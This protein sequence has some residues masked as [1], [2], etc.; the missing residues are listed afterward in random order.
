MLR[1]ARVVARNIVR[2]S[3][4]TIYG[5]LFASGLVVAGAAVGENVTQ[6]KRSLVDGASIAGGYGVAD[7]SPI[8]MGVQSSWQQQWL[9]DWQWPLSG[10]WEASLYHMPGTAGV[11]PDSNSKISAIAFAPVFRFSKAR[12]STVNLASSTSSTNSANSANNAEN[13]QPY[14]EL[15]IGV[16]QMNKREIGGRDLGIHFQFE[17]RFGIGCRFGQSQQFELGY[18]AIHFSNAYLGPKNHGINLHLFVLGYW[19]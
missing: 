17:D 9:T 13:V 8:R 12:A 10:Y 11:E 1:I 6:S 18:K 2:S 7:I 5:L 15:A 4:Y 14:L 16:A 3:L 19:F